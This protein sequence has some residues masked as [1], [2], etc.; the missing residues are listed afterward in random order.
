MVCL[1][2]QNLLRCAPDDL[3]VLVGERGPGGS[4]ADAPGHHD[5]A[6]GS[7]WQTVTSLF[8]YQN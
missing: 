5:F 7:L 8:T 4:V 2:G 1:M 6:H 3:A